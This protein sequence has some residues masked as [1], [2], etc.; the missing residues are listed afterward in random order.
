MSKSTTQNNVAPPYKKHWFSM[1]IEHSSLWGGLALIGLAVGF[2]PKVGTKL[3]AA[4][5]I[6]AWIPLVQWVYTLEVVR[7]KPKRKRLGI[8]GAAGLA[9]MAGLVIF[10]WWLLPP[11]NSSSAQTASNPASNVQTQPTQAVPPIIPK[12]QFDTESI[13]INVPDE[14]PNSLILIIFS[15]VTNLGS[16]STVKN[17]NL[18]ITINSKKQAIKG[19]PN[20]FEGSQTIGK[21]QPGISPTILHSADLLIEKTANNPI[22]SGGAASGFLVFTVDGISHKQLTSGDSSVLL[23][24]SDVTGKQYHKNLMSDGP[25]TYI[26]HLPGVRSGE[27]IEDT[28]LPKREPSPKNKGEQK[29][30]RRK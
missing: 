6:V 5:L 13:I 23:S 14:N 17:W 27:V 1:A 2:S 28:R 20:Y 22:P 24:F 3:A 11:A 18:A 10:G 12:L 26:P 7:E 16:P 15:S 4:C 25:M 21:G 8:T 19:T 30:D 29:N 9:I